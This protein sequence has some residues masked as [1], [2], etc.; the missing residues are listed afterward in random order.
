MISISDS[1]AFVQWISLPESRNVKLFAYEINLE[2]SRGGRGVVVARHIRQ[3]P[4][5][6]S[7]PLYK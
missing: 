6:L 5:H 1:E 7:R 2:Q 3:C 4:A